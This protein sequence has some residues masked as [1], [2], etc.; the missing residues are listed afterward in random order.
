MSYTTFKNVYDISGKILYFYKDSKININECS[1]TSNII[2]QGS[3][4][5]TFDSN[6]SLSNII[7]EKNIGSSGS[8]LFFE[9][10]ENSDYY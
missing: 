5:H 6:I 1:F 7:L 9:L 4:I 8:G 10:S 2:L 3:A